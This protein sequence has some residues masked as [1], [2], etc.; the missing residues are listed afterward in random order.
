VTDGYRK[1]ALMLSGLGG[2]DR[3]WLLAQFAADER[4]ELCALI[5]ELRGLGL[6]Q[7]ASLV[8]ELSLAEPVAEVPRISVAASARAAFAVLGREP[9]W[10]I[11]AVLR[12]RPWPWREAFLRLLGTEWRMSVQESVPAGGELR[13]KLAQTL[14]TA[15]ERRIEEQAAFSA[16]GEEWRK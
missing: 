1:A 16:E 4:S 11:A 14:G 8:Q 15:V 3:D 2:R 6:A 5:E 7:D 12:L 9:D 10:L 13:A